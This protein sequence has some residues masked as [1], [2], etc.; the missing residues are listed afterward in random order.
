MKKLTA[1]QL[2][3]MANKLLDINSK[4]GNKK[5]DEYPVLSSSQLKRRKSIELL[6]GPGIEFIGLDRKVYDIR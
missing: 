5:D 1:K 3:K 2:E 4:R 6:F